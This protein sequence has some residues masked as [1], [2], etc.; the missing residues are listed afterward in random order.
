MNRTHATT[1]GLFALVAAGLALIA[2]LLMPAP[3]AHAMPTGEHNASQLHGRYPYPT[4]DGGAVS[5]NRAW[6]EHVVGCGTELTSEQV[7]VI[8][9][10]RDLGAEGLTAGV[11]A[12]QIVDHFAAVLGDRTEAVTLWTATAVYAYGG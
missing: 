6:A 7:A 8:I 9:E 2:V 3:P 5:A 1:A 12:R 10:L 11:P 4:C